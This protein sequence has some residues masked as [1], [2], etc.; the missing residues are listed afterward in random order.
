MVRR[1]F[2]FVVCSLIILNC[3][4]QS[5]STPVK[6]ESVTA[7][8]GAFDKEVA[9][10]QEKLSD[11]R[12]QK[13]EGIMFATGKLNG[14]N[15]VVA[16]T[17]MGKV[18]A[19]MTTTLLIEHFRPSEV[20]FTGI[21]GGI[22]RDLRPG[23]IVIAEKTVQHDL[24]I[25]T[26]KGM[27]NTGETNPLNEKMNPVFFPADERLLKFAEMAAQKI[28]LENIKTSIGERRPGILKGVVATGDIFVSSSAKCAELRKRLGADAVEMEGA[29]VAQ[30]CYQQEVPCIIIR[31]ISDNADENAQEDMNKFYI[32]A[33]RNSA[34]LAAAI[35]DFSAEP[36]NDNKN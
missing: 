17:G 18:N 11:K 32:M 1:C 22:N 35:G 16:W 26:E 30:I 31:S 4:C 29:A 6:S 33:A 23:D 3:S 9:I 28:A 14:R 19:A 34:A 13:I 21:A 8:I 36:L 25:F 2:L 27:Q 7:I 12:E 10:L 20:I 5:L 15:T 24:G